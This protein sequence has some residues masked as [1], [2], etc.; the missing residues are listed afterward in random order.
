MNSNNRYPAE[1]I[2]AAARAAHRELAAQPARYVR[3]ATVRGQR[4]LVQIDNNG[5]A[6]PVCWSLRAWRRIVYRT[7]V[8]REFR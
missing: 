4:S 1:I 8:S 5:D 3:L 7:P 2:A 6:Y